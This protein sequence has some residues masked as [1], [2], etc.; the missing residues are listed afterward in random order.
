[1]VMTRNNNDKF[2]ITSYDALV[3]IKNVIYVHVK[4]II[5][6]NSNYI[7]PY[8][9]IMSVIIYKFQSIMKVI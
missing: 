7:R 9:E 5:I 8:H 3:Y 4:T 6:C 2:Y 1:M